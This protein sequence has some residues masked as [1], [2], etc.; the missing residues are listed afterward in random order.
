MRNGKPWPL[1]DSGSIGLRVVSGAGDLDF[2]K[3]RV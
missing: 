1:S 3:N 2:E